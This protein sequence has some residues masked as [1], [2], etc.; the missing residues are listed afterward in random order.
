MD[1]DPARP[2]PAPRRPPAWH[3]SPAWRQRAREALAFAWRRAADVR[4]PQ[5]AASLTFTTVLSLVPV[6]AIALAIFAAFPLFADYRAAFEKLL[7]KSL[8]PE[9]M[10]NTILR[11]LNDFAAKAARLTAAGLVL[12]AFAAMSMALTVDRV[13]NDI[14]R[15]HVRRPLAQR[16]LVYWALITLGPIALG[17]S[18][19]LTSYLFSITSGLVGQL[20]PAMLGV[21]DIVPLAVGGFAL[22]ALYVHVPNRSVRWRDAL[23]GG[24][25]ASA[26]GE[27]M[28]NAFAVYIARASYASIYGAFAALPLFLLWVYLSWLV[29]LFGAVLVAVLP[30]LRHT[31]FADEARPGNAFVTAVAIL[32]EMLLAQLTGMDEGRVAAEALARRVRSPVEDVELMLHRLEE[33]RYVSQLDGLHAGK[34]LLTCDPSRATL[35]PLF[36]RLAVDPGSGLVATEGA[37]LADWMRLGLEADWIRRPLVLLLAE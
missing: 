1:H 37:P 36:A 19:T 34:W 31:R 11:Y 22:A 26:T 20:R 25:V 7:V 14:W 8:L 2:D 24:F 13:L 30:A 18:L 23:A 15:V 28:K 27:L 16:V 4:L 21:L 29:T 12:L 35:V 33:L 6:L 9:A 3:V 32:R 10:S 5:V 17:A